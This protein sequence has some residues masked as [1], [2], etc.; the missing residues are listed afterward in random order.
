[1]LSNWYKLAPRNKKLQSETATVEINHFTCKKCVFSLFHYLQFAFQYEQEAQ[2][3]GCV[4]D[5]GGHGGCDCWHVTLLE[6]EAFRNCHRS[7]GSV[8]LT[9]M[10]GLAKMEVDHRQPYSYLL[11]A[12]VVVSVLVHLKFSVQALHLGPYSVLD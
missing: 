8:S 10:V 4:V 9:L 2:T 3:N 11:A 1:M 5:G 7:L 6:L 12:V